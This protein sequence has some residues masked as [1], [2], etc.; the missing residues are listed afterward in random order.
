MP[1]NPSRPNSYYNCILIEVKP[2][3]KRLSESWPKSPSNLSV[4]F[5][6]GKWVSSPGSPLGKALALLPMQRPL[7]VEFSISAPRGKEIIWACDSRARAHYINNVQELF[8]GI[9]SFT[10]SPEGLWQ[11]RSVSSSSLCRLWCWLHS[12]GWRLS[13]RPLQVNKDPLNTIW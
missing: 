5:D 11:W 4:T 3:N 10:L 12:L 2:V 13:L 7:P 1:Q 8:P 9:I 6:Q